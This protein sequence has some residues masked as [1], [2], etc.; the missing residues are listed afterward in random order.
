[1]TKKEKLQQR[2]VELNLEFDEKATIA[3][4]EALIS[5]QEAKTFD[6]P[7]EHTEEVGEPEEEVEAPTA[8]KKATQ[9]VV[10]DANGGYVR[11]YSVEK[12]GENFE[13]LAESFVS[14]PERKSFTVTVE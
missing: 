9:A 6:K 4:L 1:M 5:E 3:D 13:E 7:E 12:H 2:A 11:T 10:T 14:H 8:S